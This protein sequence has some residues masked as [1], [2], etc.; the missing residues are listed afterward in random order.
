[1]PYNHQICL[2]Q[3][4]KEQFINKELQDIVNT[5]TRQKCLLSQERTI[6]SQVN[7]LSQLSSSFE[8]R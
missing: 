8:A 5:K 2:S 6:L 1:M 4:S 7:E 3:V